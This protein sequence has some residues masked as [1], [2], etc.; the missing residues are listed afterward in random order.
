MKIKFGALLLTVPV[1]LAGCS[2]FWNILP[3]SSS[4]STTTTTPTTLSSGVF[5][6]LNQKAMQIT[7]YSIASGNLVQISGSPY[8][9]SAAP[10]CISVAPNGGFLYV[11]TVSGIYLYSVQ[12][13]GGLSIGNNGAPISSDI[14]AAM[15][16]EG[17]WLID[18]YVPNSGQVQ[19][20]A[21]P[22]NALT[23]AYTGL[24]S[25]PPYQIF[26]VKASEVDL[27]GFR[28]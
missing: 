17:A 26:I 18:A 19:F 7:A 4:T 12:S 21:I 9:L 13:G 8:T 3:S 23:G 28:L 1:F 15:Q 5:Y 20:D 14:P 10:Y 16:I 25:A 22:I 6:V 24:G 2:G 27:P 11:G